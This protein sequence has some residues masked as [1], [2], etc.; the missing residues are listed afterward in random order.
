MSYFLLMA[1]GNLTKL[2]FNGGNGSLE[3]P[4]PTIKG[5]F[6]G[7]LAFIMITDVHVWRYI[8]EFL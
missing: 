1:I 2:E 4:G 6:N 8:A 3:R 7:R 5:E